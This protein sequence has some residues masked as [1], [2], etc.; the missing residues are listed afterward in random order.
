MSHDRMTACILR[1]CRGTV[2]LTFCSFQQLGAHGDGTVCG[3][4]PAG[5]L[6]ETREFFNCF[7]AV[8]TAR[9]NLRG[10]PFLCEIYY[11]IRPNLVDPSE[12]CSELLL[13]APTEYKFGPGKQKSTKHFTNFTLHL[14]RSRP[15]SKLFLEAC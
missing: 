14:S 1:V 4:G 5:S 3:W 7:E 13:H 10:S 12:P 6:D 8:S 15:A 11:S 2:R 9:A